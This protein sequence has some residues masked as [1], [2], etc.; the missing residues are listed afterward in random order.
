MPK[1]KTAGGS[2]ERGSALQRHFVREIESVDGVSVVCSTS[3]GEVSLSIPDESI[4]PYAVAVA[5][6]YGAELNFADLHDRAEPRYT[7]GNVA[8]K[9]SGF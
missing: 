9:V 7:T 6:G 1:V 8:V 3:T 4:L 5:R 2:I